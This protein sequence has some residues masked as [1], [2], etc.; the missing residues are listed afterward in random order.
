M[1]ATGSVTVIGAKNGRKELYAEGWA[2]L[3]RLELFPRVVSV[4]ED[5]LIDGLGVSGGESFDVIK[6]VLQVTNL[7]SGWH[8]Y[9]LAASSAKSPTIYGVIAGSDLVCEIPY[10]K[11]IP[12]YS[13]APGEARPRRSMCRRTSWCLC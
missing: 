11:P 2:S 5:G 12:Q 10:S 6:V 3:V 13:S 9:V 7:N 1:G 8:L 4:S